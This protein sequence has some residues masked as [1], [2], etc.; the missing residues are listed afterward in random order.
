[1]KHVFLVKEI[2]SGGLQMTRAAFSTAAKAHEYVDEHLELIRHT[3]MR[4]EFPVECW[5]VDYDFKQ[6]QNN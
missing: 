2:L 4:Y 6:E 5:T 3:K 1:M